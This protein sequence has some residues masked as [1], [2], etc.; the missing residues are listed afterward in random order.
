MRKKLTAFR[1]SESDP[2]DKMN[3]MKEFKKNEIHSVTIDGYSSEAFGVCHIGGR[4]V[5]VPRAIPGEEWEIRIVKVSSAAVYGR[6]EKLLLP[7]P[8][9]REPDCPGYGKCGGCDCRHM[10]YDEELRFKLDKVNAALR[11]IGKQTL[12]AE[13]ILGSDS[14]LRY[15]NKA[16]FAVAE[17]ESA[18]AFGFFRERSHELIAVGDCLIQSELSVRAARAVTDFMREHG[19][20][21]YDEETGKG[22][23]RHVF[24]REAVH[25]SDAIVCVV[26]ARGFGALTQTLAEA[27]RASCPELSGIVLNVNKTRGNTVLA[28]DFY[29]L[30]GEAELHDT[31]CGLRFAIAPQAFFQINPAQA[32]KLYRRAAEFALSGKRDLLFDL[33]CGAGT[34]SLCLARGAKAVIGAEIVP[35]AVENAAANAARNEIRN[36]EFLCADAGE[37]AKLLAARGLRPDAVVVDPP[38]KGMDAAAV[39]AVCSMEPE[40][41]VYVSCNPSTL[42]RDILRFNACGYALEQATAVDMFPRTC[43]VETVVLLSKGEVD[44]KKIRVEFSL[45]DMDMS[46]FQDGATYTQIKDYVLEHSGL[47]V[48]NLYISQIKRKCGIEVGKNYNLPKSED[49]R[50]PLCPPEKEKA[51]REAFKYFGI[52]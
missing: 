13:E 23:V 2:C 8:A 34:I 15:R 6:G 9:R 41:V 28:G 35:Q 32:E 1:L 44:S 48:S 45:E 11:H 51:I 50:Q 52:I 39:E 26:A 31:L 25:G 18:P 5:F 43:H 27:L 40:R 49:S 17:G 46:E 36:A 4:A 19:I 16:V 20:P 38:R 14:V 33:Y 22:V 42:A 24:C 12:Q 47:K 10:D 37:A 21:A 29:T 30:W 3:T 7:S